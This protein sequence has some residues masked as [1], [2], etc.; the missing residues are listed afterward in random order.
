MIIDIVD[1]MAA[2]ITPVSQYMT[3]FYIYLFQQWN[4]ACDI[5]SLSLTDL[6][7]AYEELRTYSAKLYEISA[8]TERLAQENYSKTR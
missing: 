5:I 7:K 8:K 1:Q 6:A 2:V 3:S 4:G